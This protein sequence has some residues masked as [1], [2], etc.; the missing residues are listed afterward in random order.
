M[1]S[2]HPS[3][4]VI[5]CGVCSKSFVNYD[6]AQAHVDDHDS[7][8]P[9]LQNVNIFPC[10]Q[11]E[12]TYVNQNDLNNYTC[13]TH[14]VNPEVMPSI[15]TSLTCE[16]IQQQISSIHEEIRLLQNIHSQNGQ[17][18]RMRRLEG[19]AISLQSQLTNLSNN[20]KQYNDKIDKINQNIENLISSSLPNQNSQFEYQPNTQPK[21]QP[22][23]QPTMPAPRVNS[24]PTAQPVK[25]Q[26]LKG[27]DKMLIVGTSVS[28]THLTL[29]TKRE[30]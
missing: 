17:D 14:P 13:S 6:D 16:P 30:V 23:P 3:E 29:P 9:I 24:L 10:N 7:E 4:N 21:V 20:F 28:Y 12:I 11:C 22:N 27:K 5:I 25:P 8:V 18:E 2:A 19:L 1:R 15:N 26:K